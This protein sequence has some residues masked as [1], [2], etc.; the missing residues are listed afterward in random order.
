[1]R[2]EECAAVA[3][4]AAAAA[5]REVVMRKKVRA[6]SNP[7]STNA[8]TL[9]HTHTH[10]TTCEG[11][12]IFAFCKMYLHIFSVT[13]FPAAFISISTAC[14][15]LRAQKR[16]I[17]IAAAS[18]LSCHRAH[19]PPPLQPEPVQCGAHTRRDD[20]HMWPVCENV[21]NMS[22][23]W[24]RTSAWMCA[25]GGRIWA[26]RWPCPPDARRKRSAFAVNVIDIGRVGRSENISDCGRVFLKFIR[27]SH[28]DCISWGFGD[29]AQPCCNN[30]F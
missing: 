25:R 1:M 21:M 15:T 23:R 26:H 19:P 17:K 18:W 12:G 29:V 7:E 6:S 28:L 8:M 9:S 5:A 16:Y 11:E 13:S 3:V 27:I 24:R 14:Q 22:M 10:T 30:M 2:C 4:A 20:V